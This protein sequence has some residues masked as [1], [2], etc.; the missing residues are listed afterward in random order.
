MEGVGRGKMEGV[1]KKYL[2]MARWWHQ[3][4]PAVGGGRKGI[5][6]QQGD[7]AAIGLQGRRRILDQSL[8]PSVGGRA[9]RLETGRLR[10]GP[11]LVVWV[12]S[13]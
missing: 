10:R 8:L 6:E 2:D 1:R 4:E 9:P 3:G 11:V 5:G 13:G 7:Q 12:R